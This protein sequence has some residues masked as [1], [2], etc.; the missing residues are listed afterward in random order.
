MQQITTVIAI[1]LLLVVVFQFLG[2]SQM[3][4]S[5]FKFIFGGF[6][7]YLPTISISIN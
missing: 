6:L 5:I 2:L 7:D 1:F 4:G 3:I